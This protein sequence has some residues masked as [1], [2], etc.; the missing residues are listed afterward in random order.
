MSPTFSQRASVPENVLFR[1]L[2]GEAVIL[3]L[4]RESYYGLDD[5]GTR[6]WLAVT[7]A[8]SI[9]AALASLQREYDV[10]D[11]TVRADLAELLDR[12]VERGLI[13]LSDG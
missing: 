1:E 8:E 13:E 11:D 7:E 5:V 2:D 4:E 6:M 12:L 3:D 10:D 9:E